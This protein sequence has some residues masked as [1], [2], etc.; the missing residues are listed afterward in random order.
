MKQE[1]N[2]VI[3]NND[4]MPVFVGN[5]NECCKFLNTTQASFHCLVT[6]TKNGIIKGKKYRAYKIDEEE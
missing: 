6:R 4:D 3:Y 5:T 1:A 2:Y